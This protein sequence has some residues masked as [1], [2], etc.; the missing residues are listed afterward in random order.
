MVTMILLPVEHLEAVEVVTVAAV[1]V[2]DEGEVAV[3]VTVTSVTHPHDGV[4]FAI[5]PNIRCPNAIRRRSLN[6][7][8]QRKDTVPLLQYQLPQL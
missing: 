4:N 1:A 8:D 7:F 2:V 5:L 6:G 3:V